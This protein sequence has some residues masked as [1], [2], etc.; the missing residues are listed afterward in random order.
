[1]IVLI[2]EEEKLSIVSRE[3]HNITKKIDF[4]DEIDLSNLSDLDDFNDLMSLISFVKVNENEY[5]LCRFERNNV[6]CHNKN[7][8][9]IKRFSKSI[10]SKSNLNHSLSYFKYRRLER[11]L[12]SNISWD[13]NWVI[14]Y[15]SYLLLKYETH[16]NVEICTSIKFVTYLY[17]Y[18]FKKS[19]HVDVSIEITLIV[20]ES[21]RRINHERAHR[22]DIVEF[23]DEIK[24]YHDVKWMSFCEIAWR[25]LE[26]KIEKIK[27]S[28][29]RFQI[30]LKNQQRLLINSNDSIIVEI[31]QINEK[32]R[33]ITLIEYFK[34][35]KRAQQM[36]KQ[37]NFSFYEHNIVV[38]DLKNYFY[39]D[40][41]EH[42]V[43]DKREKI[44]NI[45]KRNQCVDRI[46]FISFKIDDVFYLRLLLF[47]RKKC[48]SFENL[49]TIFVQI[50]S[51]KKSVTK[52]RL[53]K[54]YHDVCI[55]LKLIDNDDEW[56]VV[57]TKTIE[58]DTIAMIKSLMMTILLKCVS[59]QS[60]KLWKKYKFA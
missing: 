1:M 30:H 21:M 58:F 42:F 18:V 50:E 28:I 27:L 38:R 59:T 22:N 16:I 48:T 15:N 24:I 23:V 9:C 5:F 53:M 14:F 56:H 31:F 13:N 43:W 6:V 54:I 33:Q 49:R 40:I 60:L 17:K 51:A 57:M 55:T 12:V 26:L 4:V 52:S 11:E 7:D 36:K 19:N 39:H 32:F 25:I 45:R 37:N 3:R 20:N 8:N 10:C 47:N 34:M 2:V 35:N 46:Y 29:N 44:W 41:L